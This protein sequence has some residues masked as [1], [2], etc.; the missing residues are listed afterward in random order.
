MSELS[1][2]SSVE[3]K[4]VIHELVQ[5]MIQKSFREDPISESIEN[6]A[7][8]SMKDHQ[9]DVS[10]SSEMITT[11]RDHLAKLLFWSVI[12]YFVGFHLFKNYM[13]TELFT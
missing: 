2:P 10:E 4:E 7:I 6:M 9:V 5:N 12:S 1:Q 13:H 3:V 11:S 8:A